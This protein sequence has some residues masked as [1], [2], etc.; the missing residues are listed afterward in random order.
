MLKVKATIIILLFSIF[1]HYIIVSLASED[2]HA[3]KRRIMMKEQIIS[4]GVSDEKVLD[5]M[6]KVERH[7][8]V[9]PY[10]IDSAYGD[11]PLPIGYRQTISQPYIVA[12]MTEALGL[13]GNEKILEVGTGSGYQAAVLS[14]IVREVYTIEIVKPLAEEAQKRLKSLD[15]KN[16]KIKCGD[17]YLGWP[18][19][20]PFDA[21]IVTAAP[22]KVPEKLVEQLKVGGNMLI[23]VGS[24]FQNLYRITKTKNGVKKES[25]LPV[26]FVPMIKGN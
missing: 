9:P 6:F 2:I 10:L 11:T 25:L 19:F 1:Y 16:I 8:F 14:K 26:R 13:K 18:E 23:P 17:G 7:L 12:F 15:Y 24:F 3:I 4:R 22:K 20:A 5:A 21:I